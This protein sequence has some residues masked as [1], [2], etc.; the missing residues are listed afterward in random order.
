MSFFVLGNLFIK[1]NIL[2]IKSTHYY[3]RSFH[4]S[5]KWH[6]KKKKTGKFQI[7]IYIDGHLYL[8]DEEKNAISLYG[9]FGNFPQ[10]S[11]RNKIK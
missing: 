9:I 3:I 6:V 8:E 4:N 2:I 10:I 7:K 1:K 11:L 5:R